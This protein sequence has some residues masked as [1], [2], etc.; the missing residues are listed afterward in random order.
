MEAVPLCRGAGGLQAGFGARSPEEA[1]P[2]AG[3]ESTSRAVGAL[4]VVDLQGH[5]CFLLSLP[6]SWPGA[7]KLFLGDVAGAARVG[8]P[9]LG[10]QV[11]G[12][13]LVGRG[14]KRGPK[15]APGT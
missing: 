6:L 3:A 1:V 10:S 11:L 8:G 7:L 4:G 5:L 15:I 13:R 9:H 14:G 12:V 2:G